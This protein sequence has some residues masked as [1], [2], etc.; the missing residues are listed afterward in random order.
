MMIPR[1]I[2]YCWFGPN[3][4][5]QDELRCIQSWKKY[6]P[7]YEIVLWNE[8][9]FNV[10]VNL[11]VEQAYNEQKWAFV[12]DYARFWILY[13]F[14]GIYFDTDVELINQIDDI[15]SSGP[16]MGFEKK[17]NSNGQVAVAP[18]LGMCAEKGMHFYK[19]VLDI[20]D[21]LSFINEDGSQNDET[22][23]S[24]ITNILSSKGLK[25]VSSIQSV[26][27]ITIYP[28]DYFAP[29]DYRTGLVTMTDNTRSIHHYASSWCSPEL[30]RIQ[31]AQY[32][33]VS[34]FGEKNGIALGNLYGI[35][36]RALSR[37]KRDGLR[38]AIVYYVHLLQ[39]L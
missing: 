36:F 4:L 2:H 34:I 26:E 35:I 23:V 39:E 13:H 12:S 18:G 1:T 8:D 10:H 3:S 32:K 21:T 27:G 33:M 30:R 15:V 22:V 7:D 25:Q 14:G 31:Q 5:S 38:S 11:Y 6:C 16:F 19:E 29:L 37:I 17:S 9:N 20:Y 24:R 28:D